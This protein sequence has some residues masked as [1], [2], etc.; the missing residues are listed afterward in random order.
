MMCFIADRMT[1]CLLLNMYSSDIYLRLFDIV[2]MNETLFMSIISIVWRYCI[3]FNIG[4]D[5]LATLAYYKRAGL[6]NYVIYDGLSFQ[7]QTDPLLEYFCFDWVYGTIL[8]GNW[9]FGSRK[10][11]AIHVIYFS[12]DAPTHYIIGTNEF[13]DILKIYCVLVGSIP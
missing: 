6:F 11:H 2:I 4:P 12:L 5:F 9:C 3:S 10:N 13:T 1:Y 8:P 7:I